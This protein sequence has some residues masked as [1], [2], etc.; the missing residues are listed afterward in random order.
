[1]IP[2]IP[3]SPTRK[4]R[5]EA[6]VWCRQFSRNRL[7]DLAGIRS[8]RR[9]WLDEKTIAQSAFSRVQIGNTDRRYKVWRS[10]DGIWEGRDVYF[11]PIII[12][13]FIRY[14]VEVFRH[15]LSD[16]LHRYPDF[17]RV[18]FS[19]GPL[20]GERRI[21]FPDRLDEAA[22]TWLHSRFWQ[23][24]EKG[25]VRVHE[26]YTATFEKNACQCSGRVKVRFE[27]D[28][29]RPETNERTWEELHTVLS[30]GNL[31]E[32]DPTPRRCDP[33]LTVSMLEHLS[34]SELF[35]L[36]WKHC[37]PS[38]REVDET[39]LAAAK[40]L[41]IPGVQRAL[42]SGANPNCFLKKEGLTAIGLAVEQTRRFVDDEGGSDE[43]ADRKESL[44]LRVIDLLIDAGAAVDLAGF[45]ENTPLAEACLNSSA[46]VITHLLEH[47]ADPS[48]LCFYDDYLGDWGGA[49]ENADYRCNPHADNDDTTAWDALTKFYPPP[50]EGVYIKPVSP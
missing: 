21:H 44:A 45:D 12:P 39:V 33:G 31:P 29:N 36:N 37:L 30:N 9:A 41:D 43:V 23:I 16:T 50:Y 11:E 6:Y 38:L 24:A 25:D 27:I 42:A 13:T 32:I 2:N 8:A 34:T 7:A 5:H 18:E 48:I 40:G 3:V 15:A 35:A 19:D 22:T 17:T 4:P 14:A 46:K 47:G 26:G 1:M 28:L 10:F 20:I 49:W